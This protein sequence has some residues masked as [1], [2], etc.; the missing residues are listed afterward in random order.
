MSVVN[1]SSQDKKTD[2]DPGHEE[3]HS[4]T[5]TEDNKQVQTYCNIII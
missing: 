3:D 1:M 5:A 4:S 2:S